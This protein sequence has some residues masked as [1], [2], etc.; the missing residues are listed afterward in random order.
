MPN[1]INIPQAPGKGYHTEWFSALVLLCTITVRYCG[2]GTLLGQICCSPLLF[3]VAGVQ[4]P[5]S[6]SSTPGLAFLCLKADKYV[7]NKGQIWDL[8][9]KQVT[10]AWRWSSWRW[11]Q[12]SGVTS[13]MLFP[14]HADRQNSFLSVLLVLCRHKIHHRFHSIFPW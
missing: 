11:C 4:E 7:L 6:H 13:E 1:D 2:S 3:T 12:M 9:M 10:S 8:H 5:L 14:E